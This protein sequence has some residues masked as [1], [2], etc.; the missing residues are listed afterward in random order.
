MAYLTSLSTD[1]NY[2]SL[3]NC[4]RVNFCAMQTLLVTL[5]GVFLYYLPHPTPLI[6]CNWYFCTIYIP[7]GP[8][9]RGIFALL[10]N[11]RGH[12][13]TMYPSSSSLLSTYMGGIYAPL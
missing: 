9:V 11:V 1:T 13:C 8:S 5:L 2:H 3:G 7:L 6:F 12:F 10:I 4:V